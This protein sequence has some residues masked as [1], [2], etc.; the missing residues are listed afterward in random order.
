MCDLLTCAKEPSAHCVLRK[1]WV[2]CADGSP[3]LK[4]WKDIDI[5]HIEDNEDINYC[6]PVCVDTLASYQKSSSEECNLG[7]LLN[8]SRSLNL[9]GVEIKNDAEITIMKV[10]LSEALGN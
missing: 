10:V 2:H 9:E 3:C 1:L 6:C 5:E 4:Y 8:C 7:N